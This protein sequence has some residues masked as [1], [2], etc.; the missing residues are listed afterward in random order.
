MRPFF[1]VVIPS[2]NR[3]EMLA[4]ALDSVWRQTFL[5]YEVIVVDDGSTDGT[6]AYLATLGA[7]VKTI[8]QQ[9]RGPAAA[10]NAGAKIACGEYL[11]FLDSDDELLPSALASYAFAI[12]ETARPSL[13]SGCLAEFRDGDARLSDEGASF[14][15]RR[16]ETYF[17]AAAEG[18]YVGTCH[19]AVRRELLVTSGGF[20]EAIRVAEDHD[21]VLRLGSAPGFVEIKSPPSVARR[22][23]TGSIS[24]DGPHLYRGLAT[25]VRRASNGMY[26]QGTTSRNSARSIVSGH[27]RSSSFALAGGGHVKYASLL[28]L[29]SLGIHARQRRW[30]YIAAFPLVLAWHSLVPS[31][32]GRPVS[33][34]PAARR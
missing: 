2:Y 5:D 1:S 20:D 33:S 7:R 32:R 25:I 15:S 14:V 16:F 29:H 8:R 34:F 13:L 21:F 18:I 27:A 26:G 9:N 28:Y 3:C 19:L 11:A 10:R 23:H 4:C 6:A 24:S 30:R 12:E 22:R 17:A 31:R